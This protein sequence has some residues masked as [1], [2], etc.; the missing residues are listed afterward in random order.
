VLLCGT[1]A[2]QE[3]EQQQAFTIGSL[4]AYFVSGGLTTGASLLAEDGGYFLGGELSVLRLHRG[5]LLGL[6][7]DGYHDFGAERT[8]GTAGVE[9]GYKLVGIDG[10]AA[11]RF[12]SDDVAFGPTGR[13]FV[14]VGILSVYGRYAYFHELQRSD[15]DHLIQVGALLKFPLAAWGG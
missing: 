2:A 12:G 9:L 1:A 7:G 3:E 15:N 14:T 6:Y 8:Y 10:G 4:P 13:L 11:A 5:W